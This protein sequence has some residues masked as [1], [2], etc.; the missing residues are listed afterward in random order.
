MPAS[1]THS[2]CAL[3]DFSHSS[4]AHL[5]RFVWVSLGCCFLFARAQGVS[6]GS[7][8]SVV[9]SPSA[10]ILPPTL[11]SLSPIPANGTSSL[12][13]LPRPIRTNLTTLHHEAEHC[14]FRDRV[15]PSCRD[16]ERGSCLRDLQKVRERESSTSISGSLRSRQL[17]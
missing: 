12:N 7:V 1:I 4:S 6:I 16:A 10:L 2:C 15:L 13:F 5:S 14:N 8:C 9:G 11:L 17:K 3:W